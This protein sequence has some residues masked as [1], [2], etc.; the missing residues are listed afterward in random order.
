MFEGQLLSSGPDTGLTT[1]V[2]GP[3]RK[4]ILLEKYVRK[5]QAML[6]MSMRGRSSRSGPH[7]RLP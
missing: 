6:A 3:D 4:E 7:F 2:D 1:H 5:P